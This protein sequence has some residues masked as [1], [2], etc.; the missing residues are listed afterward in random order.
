[1]NAIGI[2][3][4]TAAMQPSIVPAHCTPRFSI[5]C[6]ENK[7]NAHPTAERRMVLAAIVE[8]ALLQLAGGCI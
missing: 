2:G 6:R 3:T 7:G 4:I 1:M 8:A 5:I